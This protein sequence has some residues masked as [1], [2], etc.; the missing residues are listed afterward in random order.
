MN[1]EDARE[2]DNIMFYRLVGESISLWSETEGFIAVIGALLLGT[3][4]EKAGIVFF[5]TPNFY[6]WLSIIDDLFI[7]DK[8]FESLRPAWGE[9]AERLKK[10]ND[11]RVRLAHHSYNDRR[12]IKGVP[13]LRPNRIDARSKSKK[14]APLDA[15]QILAFIAKFSPL[16]AKLGGLIRQMHAIRRA[17]LQKSSSPDSGQPHPKDAQ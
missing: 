2:I 10:M 1:E 4:D 6:S 11:T 8:D 14:Y 7:L 16:I 3:S 9:I 13:A 5:S 17:S 15:E 12:K